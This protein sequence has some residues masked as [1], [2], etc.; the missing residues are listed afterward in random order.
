[1][2]PRRLFVLLGLGLFGCAS[3]PPVAPTPTPGPEA[4]VAAEGTAPP[5]AEEVATTPAVAESPATE[6]VAEPAP[7]EAPAKTEAVAAAAP[8]QK[9]KKATGKPAPTATTPTTAAAPA[10]PAAPPPPPAAP[11]ATAKPAAPAAATYSG[12]DACSLA[13]KGDSSVVAACA[14][15]GLKEA[16]KEMKRM[17]KKAKEAGHKTDCDDCHPDDDFGKLTKDGREKFKELARH[18]AL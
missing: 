9:K 2:N 11:A 4:P 12:P 14:K 3:Q 18:G 8:A 6:P 7:V 16:R 13:T 17:V 1:M 15:G 10:A 5:A